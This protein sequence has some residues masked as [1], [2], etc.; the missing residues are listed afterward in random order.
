M[1]ATIMHD[2]GWD[3]Y[4]A[5]W[6]LATIPASLLIGNLFYHA[7]EKR[8]LNTRTESSKEPLKLQVIDVRAANL[9]EEKKK[10]IESFEGKKCLRE[11]YARGKWCR[12][13]FCSAALLH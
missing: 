12:N 7:V 2:L 6:P 3:D 4:A 5:F 11:R 9:T 8:F 1:L 10:K 13:F